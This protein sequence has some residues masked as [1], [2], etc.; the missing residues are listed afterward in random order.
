MIRGTIA[1]RDG[2]TAEAERRG[3]GLRALRRG[4]IGPSRM[5]LCVRLRLTVVL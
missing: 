1:R 4:P 3:A 2:G 5:G